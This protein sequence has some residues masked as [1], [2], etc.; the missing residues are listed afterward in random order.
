MVVFI[1]T[2]SLIKRYIEEDGSEIIDKY[3]KNENEIFISPITPI[4]FI[5]ALKRKLR[6]KTIDL[7]NFYRAISEW[8]KEELSYNIILFN[9]ILVSEAIKLIENEPLKTLDSLQL[10]SAKLQVLDEFVTSDRKLVQVAAKYLP[11][12]ITFI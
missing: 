7:E 11:C 12:K 6:E 4:E 5:S 1:D 8:S 9:K 2:S 10:A 3:Y